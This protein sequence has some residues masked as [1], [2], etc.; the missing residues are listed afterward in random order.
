M[1]VSGVSSEGFQ[2]VALPQTAASALFQAQTATGKLNARDDADDAE[3]MPLFH[4]AVLRA[5]GGDGQA[6]KLARKPDREIADV[7]HLLHFALAFRENLSGFERDEPA[8]V[9]LGRAQG[10]AELADDF[11]ASG[12]GQS[13]PFLQTPFR[14]AL[15]GLL[16]FRA[17]S[18]ADG[19]EQLA[20]NGRNA[21]QNFAAAEPFA[22]EHAGIGFPGGRAV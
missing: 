17:V 22:A 18:P 16:V 10:V 7:N 9:L 8:Q 20:V 13:A 5:F 12:R 14:R 19:G 3:R 11:A 6:V 1:A 4:H 21:A 15:H 2:T